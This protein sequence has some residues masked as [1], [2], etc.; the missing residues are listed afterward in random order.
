MKLTIEQLNKLYSESDTCD[1]E[2]FAEFRSNVLLVVGDFFNKRYAH[3][4]ARIRDNKTLNDQTKLRITANNIQKITKTIINNILT[5]APGVTVLPKNLNEVQDQK[6]A[7]LHQSVWQDLRHRHKFSNRTRQYC[8]DFVNIG[9]CWAKTYWDPSA[10]RVVGYEQEV[11]KETGQPVLDEN[12]QPVASNRPVFAGDVVIERYFAFN[13][14]R[15]PEAK[16]FDESR[17]V[18][19][20][21]MVSIKDLKRMIESD[22]NFS[23]EEKEDL[24]HKIQ[25][26]PQDTYIIF[27]GQNGTYKSST[28]E[29]TMLREFY[30]RPCADFPN[31]WF[32]IGTSTAL[33]WEGEL[34]GSVFP[35]SYCGFD[36]VPTSPRARSIIKVLRPF[37]IEI[38]RCISSI[39]S[40]QTSIGED[41]ILLQSGTKLSAGA[42]LPGIRSVY[43]SGMEPKILAGRAGDQYLPYLNQIISMMY[44]AANLKED[45]EKQT[46][47]IDPHAMLYQSLRNKKKYAIYSQKFENFLIDIAEK[48]LRLAKIYYTEE[49][50]VPAIGRREYIN[51]PEFKAADDLN[52]QIKIEAQ[53]DDAD[54]KMGRVM[55]MNTVLQYVGKQLDKE[56]IGKIMKAYPFAND[57]EAFGDFAIDSDNIKNDILCLDRG[58]D[59]PA[60]QYDDHKYVI[61]RLIN[62]MKKADFEFLAPQ[63]QALYQKKL[64]EHEFLL[65]EQERKIMEAKQGFIPTGG[66]LT[67]CD[68]YVSKG[69][70]SKVTRARVPYDSLV[71]LIK[72]LEEQGMSLERLE[73]M[74]NGALEDMAKMLVTGQQPIAQ[75]GGPN[76]QQPTAPMP[77]TGMSQFGG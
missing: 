71:W 28:N 73:S 2:I 27:D 5:Y 61:K 7:E 39:A 75:M 3:N 14:L 21:K 30:F 57:D 53:T 15:A 48:A 16:S 67:G 13:V 76:A 65:A 56:D 64:Q 24:T 1:T 74:Q 38:S 72:R 40:A 60:H 66:F 26:S 8:E 52:Y 20:R 37:Q 9:E 42:T 33:I 11:D 70:N 50:L 77:D 22:P 69:P 25:A 35:V 62:R 34:P 49:N 31:G 54:T 51:I 45:I 17:H 4:F 32:A 43:Y 19:L 47:Q 58:Q 6:A 63:I 55:M 59:R 12:G 46:S 23:K 29:Q 44:E 68:F 18:C 41:K 10:G 36:D